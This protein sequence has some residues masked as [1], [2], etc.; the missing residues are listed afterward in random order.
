MNMVL[1]SA[2]LTGQCTQFVTQPATDVSAPAGTTLGIALLLT[3]VISIVAIVQQNHVTIGLVLLNYVLLLDAIGIV[4]IGT[5]V[6][7]FALQ[8]RTNFHRSWLQATRQTRITLQD[9]VCRTFL[10]CFPE[11]ANAFVAQMLWILQRK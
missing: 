5:F 8:E 9:Q 10:Y 11:D 1:S 7:F 6:W 2:D 3:F 4:V